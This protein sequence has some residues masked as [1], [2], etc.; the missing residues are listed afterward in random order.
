MLKYKLQIKLCAKFKCITN[1]PCSCGVVYDHAEV[2]D[3][4]LFRMLLKY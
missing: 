4:R 3:V 2:R 1:V